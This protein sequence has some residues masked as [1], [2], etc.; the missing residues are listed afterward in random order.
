MIFLTSQAVTLFGST[1]VQ[2][3]IVWYVTLN[4]GEGAWIAAFTVM[5]YLPQ[6]LISFLGGVWADRY[7]K[8]ALIIGADSGIAVITLAMWF[9]LPY[10]DENSLMLP[11]LLAMSALRSVGAGIQ[12]PAVN[13]V[14]PQLVPEEDVMRYNGIAVEK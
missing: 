10:I 7:N 6:F 3:A 1:L 5:S 12:T 11:L 13:A 9:V 8:K 2:M 4:T 14:L